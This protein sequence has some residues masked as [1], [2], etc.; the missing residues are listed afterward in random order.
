MMLSITRVTGQT[1][2]DWKTLWSI[3]TSPSDPALRSYKSSC[4]WEYKQNPITRE[5]KVQ[6]HPFVE[7]N[8]LD[9]S[10]SNANGFATDPRG[11]CAAVYANCQSRLI[12]VGFTCQYATATPAIVSA[13]KRNVHVEHRANFDDWD[14]KGPDSDVITP[15]VSDSSSQNEEVKPKVT[16]E[17]KSDK[18]S[19]DTGNKY[20]ELFVENS[21]E[22]LTNEHAGKNTTQKHQD[23][24][25]QFMKSA[26]LLKMLSKRIVKRWMK[27]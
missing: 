16:K 2:M 3:M 26:E 8:C 20:G 17:D 18:I 14:N 27:P 5:I 22:D 4:P 24:L 23:L 11:Q 13:G 9:F 21:K 15:I 1:H 19:K 25:P 7:H 10:R 6:L 12:I